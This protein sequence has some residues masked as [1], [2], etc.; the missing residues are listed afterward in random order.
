[1]SD[2]PWW[3]TPPPRPDTALA[4]RARR[5]LDTLIKPPGSLGRLE[6]LAATLAAQQGRPEPQVERV[7]ISVFAADHG[8]CAEAISSVP[9]AVTAGMVRR[10]SAGDAAIAVLARQLGAGLEVI[11]LGTLEPL[12]ALPAVV[13]ARLARGTANMRTGPAMDRETVAAA[14]EEGRRAFRRAGDCDLFIGGEMGIGNT[15]AAA[16]LGGALLGLGSEL[17]GPGTGLDAAGVERKRA[18]ID[19][20]L[21]R[22]GPHLASPLEALRRVGGLEIA[23]LTGA[24]IAAAQAR[25][26]VLVDG[27]IA[28]VAALTAVRLNPG[29]RDWLHFGHH[30]AEPGHTRLLQTL[31]AEGLLDLGMRLGEGTGA[32][33]AVPLLRMACALYREMA[34]FQEAGFT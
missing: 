10:F 11:N 17:A 19:Q 22:H 3:H 23:G 32:A 33:A 30:S 15:T 9:Q 5:R 27:F 16:A 8:V 18:V 20:A 12:P 1:M 29:V 24:F 6:A 25:S 28:T 14:L 4:A 31:A 2:T 34:T 21:H 7:H 26:P 13:D